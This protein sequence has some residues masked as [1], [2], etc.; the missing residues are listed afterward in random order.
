MR[1]KRLLTFSI[2]IARL[3]LLGIIIWRRVRPFIPYI[4]FA[5]K[6]RHD[7]AR[8]MSEIRRI[9]NPSSQPSSDQQGE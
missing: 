1:S 3:T 8:A 9:T 7:A 2:Q 4:R 6:T 5:L